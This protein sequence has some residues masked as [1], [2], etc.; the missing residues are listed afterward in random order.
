[1]KGN[2]ILI[3][4]ICG[5]FALLILLAGFQYKWVG[6]ISD[7]ERVR[8]DAR[9]KDDTRRFAEDFNREIQSIYF[10]FRLDPENIKSKDWKPFTKR[11][12]FWKSRSA[13]PQVVKSI[14]YIPSAED[15]LPLRF[16]PGSGEFLEAEQS[17]ELRQSKTEI[18]KS[19]GSVPVIEFRDNAK[20]NHLA[21]IVPVVGKTLASDQTRIRNNDNSGNVR[22][23]EVTYVNP[24]RAGSL[25]VFLSP[26]QIRNEILAKLSSKYFSGSEEGSYNVSIKKAGSEKVFES[27]GKINGKPDAS[28]KIFDLRPSDLAFFP[29]NAG[30]AVIESQIREGENGSII[31][32]ETY[33]DKRSN[34]EVGEK[35]VDVNLRQIDKGKARI[36][37]FEGET[38]G[39]EGIWDLSVQHSSGSINNFIAGA[40]M[41]NL[42]ISFGI[43]ALLA[44]SMLLILIASQ[45]AK[46]LAQRQIDF[47]SSVTHEFRTPLSVI[48]SAGENLSDGVVS[49]KEKISGYG[50]LIKNEGRKLTEMVE[51]ILEFAGARSGKQKYDLRSLDA[52][53]VI[54]NAL[55]DCSH[56]IN[57]AGFVAETRV[58]RGLPKIMADEKALTRV[59]QNLVNNS[60]KYSNGSKW[61]RVSAGGDSG[62]VRIAVEDRGIGV[63][64]AEKKHLFEPFYRSERVVND[65]ISGNGLGLSLVKQII[66]A[67]GGK[68]EV[69]SEPGK[70][71]KFTI[72][73]PANGSG[74]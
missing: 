7:S 48:Y 66:D 69:E 43:L 33:R 2:W 68:I 17:A 29:E 49:E 19:S 28:V 16:M 27:G 63:S 40:R 14:A 41:T 56:A 4:G 39:Y 22:T 13:A 62:L 65:Q 46:L 9:V 3:L 57:D 73:L 52:K 20:S 50:S 44:V 37:I 55:A 61:V 74:N 47:V 35:E 10:S 59:I 51:Q 58:P 70:G 67:H 53:D 12:L 1:M 6:Q 72:F 15:K 8:L 64:A 30:D 60:L 26:E 42:L 21:L 18:E 71:S 36:A 25:V 38:A 31:V 24:Q 45:R 54:D 34:V 5:L 32:S 23:R 11:Y